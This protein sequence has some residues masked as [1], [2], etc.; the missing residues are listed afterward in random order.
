VVQG[1]GGLTLPVGLDA[2]GDP[3]SLGQAHGATGQLGLPR[4]L[5]LDFLPLAT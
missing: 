1:E 4:R 3:A 5:Q 2:D